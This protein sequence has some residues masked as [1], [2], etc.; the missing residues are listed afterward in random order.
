MA[1]FHLNKNFRDNPL[2]FGDLQLI[3][4]GRIHFEPGDVMASHMHNSWFELTIITDGAGSVSTNGISTPVRRGDIYL[5]YPRESHKIESSESSP[6]KYDFFSFYTYSEEYIGEL[7]KI[8]E[9]FTPYDRVFSD[10]RV[11]A[12][13]CDAILEFINGGD[14]S[15]ELLHSLFKQ[16]LIFIIRSFKSREA[17]RIFYSVTEKE[18]LC[19]Q[20]MNYIDTHIYTITSLEELG[21]TLKYNYS[22][23]STVFKKTTGESI[24]SYYQKKR[25]D[26][27]RLL[28][29]ENSMK[30]TEIAAA[31]NYSSLYSFSHAFK[32][33]YGCSPKLYFKMQ[34][35]K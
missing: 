15:E 14:F 22:Y 28:I 6:L 10:E 24:S 3:Q 9:Y 31:L 30:I 11:A 4:I 29:L 21:S 23:L 5:S 18:E 19:Y 26:T 33:K 2:I 12:L 20:I 1:K 34:K 7:E 25:L 16:I 8:V 35:E 32:E 17:K 27:A 13:V